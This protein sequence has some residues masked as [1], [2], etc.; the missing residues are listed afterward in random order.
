MSDSKKGA[1]SFDGKRILITGGTG[2]LGKALTRRLLSGEHGKPEKIVIFSRDEAKQYDMRL[3]FLNFLAA[4]E[5]VIYE[6]SQH[7]LDFRIGDI[8]DYQS[9]SSALRQVDIVVNTAA[10]KQVPSCEYVPSEAVATNINGAT[11]ICRA[12][13]NLN[14]PIETVIGVS[15]DKAC[16]PISVMGMTKAIQERIFI[17]ANMHCPDTRFVCVR[18]GNVLASRGSVVPLFHSQVGQGGPVTITTAE[19]TR[20][21]LPLDHAV[22]TIVAAY[23]QA[24]QGEI[25]VPRIPAI[26]ILNVAKALINGRDIPIKEVGVRPGEKIHEVLVSE[27]EIYRTSICN[28]YFAI[29]PILPELSTED[30][31]KKAFLGNEF[32]SDYQTI[33]LEETRTLL[34][35]EGLTIEDQ[36][37]FSDFF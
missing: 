8:R 28:G 19:M 22:D 5:E 36:P 10:L 37:V 11:N 15:T 3:G 16:K 18:Y 25:F 30:G 24:R 21:L 27:D 34:E 12:I 20:F 31:R 4:T 9:I 2:S 17:T 23:S 1:G 13:E 6:D 32:S 35:K 33:S 26:L 7:I 14:L 29:Q